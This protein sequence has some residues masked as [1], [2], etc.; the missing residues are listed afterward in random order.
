M[1]GLFRPSLPVWVFRYSV[2]HSA[3]QDLLG[4]ILQPPHAPPHVCGVTVPTLFGHLCSRIC[5]F[6]NLIY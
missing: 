4:L 3:H 5:I 6:L 1:F 2:A